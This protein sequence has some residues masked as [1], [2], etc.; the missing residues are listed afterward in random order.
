VFAEL[1]FLCVSAVDLKKKYGYGAWVQ[2]EHDGRGCANMTVD[3]KFFRAVEPN[4]YD[5]G[6]SLLLLANAFARFRA[7]PPVRLL[8]CRVIIAIRFDSV[9]LSLF[10]I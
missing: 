3:G 9:G 5:P 8:T 10:M 7:P 2:L 6:R 4:V 1:L